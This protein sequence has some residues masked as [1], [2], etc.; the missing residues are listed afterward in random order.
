MKRLSL[1][2]LALAAVVCHAAERPNILWITNEDHG[3]HLG[4]YGDDFATTPVMDALAAK[5]MLYKRAWS[6]APVCAAARTTLIAGIYGPSSGGQHM[7]SMVPM[8]EGKKMYPQF[9]RE[10][11][12]YC[13]NRSKEDYNLVKPDGVWDDSSR[14]GHWKNRPEG[15]PFFAIFN[16]TLSHESKLRVRPH[17]AIHDPAKVRVPAYH[18]DTPEVRQDWAQYYDT[19][20]NA[21]A[22]AGKV[23]AEVAEAGLAEDTIVFLYA[24]HGAGMS[25]NKRWPSNSGLH[26]P[27]IVYFPDKWKHLAPKDYAEG[28]KSDRMVSFVDL[29]PT[30]LSIV[31]IE[32]PEWMQGHAFAGEFQTEPPEFMHGFR[33]RMDERYDMVRSVTDGR[34]VYLRNYMPHVS[35]G[36]HVN[37]Q[38]ITPSTAVWRAKYDAGELNTVQSRFW[39]VPKDSEELYDLEA[40]PDEVENLASSTE[41][42]EVLEKLRSAVR[43]HAIA[44]HDTGFLPEG[45]FHRRSDGKS[46]YDMARDGSSYPMEE[47]MEAAELASKPTEGDVDKVQALLDADDSAIR[48]WAA[49]GLL[50]RGKSAV[51]AAGEALMQVA[52][53]DEG[54][55]AKVAAA[56]ALAEHGS[57]DAQ[58]G[59]VAELVEMANWE[60][61]DNVFTSLAA[62]TAIDNLTSSAKPEIPVIKA[63]PT[64]GVS[65]DGRY[66][67]YIGN[68]VSSYGW[69]TGAPVTPVNKKPKKTP[70]AK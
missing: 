8:P 24:D 59:A 60:K 34:Y 21:D 53:N 48:Y 20:S 66:G 55:E 64:K 23:L 52:E 25:R 17:E 29:A 43:E 31:G 2:F 14:N 5:G 22:E 10:Q 67:G 6:N 32:P 47:V 63:L 1:L 45:E 28:G 4:C 27:M 68:L 51:D 12:Y 58:E 38:F 39:N 30:L 54:P 57:G 42:Q 36:Q 40:D 33:G 7:R 3:P 65:P 62:I 46:P 35:Q 11:G 41:H 50:L 69:E 16:C 15:S 9:L 18:P 26:V 61:T 70:K 37:Y 19:V 56:W 44:I 13:T 49:V